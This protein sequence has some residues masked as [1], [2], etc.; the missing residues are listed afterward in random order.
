MTATVLVL[1]SWMSLSTGTHRC[2]RNFR[3]FS[4]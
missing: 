4:K 1:T 2:N 3:S